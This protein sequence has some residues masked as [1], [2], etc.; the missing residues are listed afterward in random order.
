MASSMLVTVD[1]SGAYKWRI[2]FVFV[3]CYAERRYEKN[4]FQL[5]SPNTFIC[6]TDVIQSVK[7]WLWLGRQFPLWMGAMFVVTHIISKC[8]HAGSNRASGHLNAF[9]NLSRKMPTM[10]INKL[11]YPSGTTLLSDHRGAL[12]QLLHSNRVFAA[13]HHRFLVTPYI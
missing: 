7:I 9:G 1:V 3:F 6:T 13:Q 8:K 2:C 12:F 10:Q 4:R 5:N 11:R